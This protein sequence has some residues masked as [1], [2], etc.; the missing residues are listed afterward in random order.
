MFKIGDRVYTKAHN[1][2][3]VCYAG[4]IIDISDNTA[5]IKYDDWGNFWTSKKII[6][7]IIILCA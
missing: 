6:F 7:R 4:T 5:L 1:K 3:P 2:K